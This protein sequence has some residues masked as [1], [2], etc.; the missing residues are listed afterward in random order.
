MDKKESRQ[1]VP[2]GL[3]VCLKLRPASGPLLSLN[4]HWACSILRQPFVK[5]LI[6]VS[7]S[8]GVAVSPWGIVAWKPPITAL[9]EQSCGRT[10]TMRTMARAFLTKDNSLPLAPRRNHPALRFLSPLMLFIPFKFSIEDRIY[11]ISLDSQ[12]LN[13]AVISLNR[14]NIALF[15]ILSSFFKVS[16]IIGCIYL[17]FLYV[18]GEIHGET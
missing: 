16:C 1:D 11:R 5:P 7:L 9:S 10:A 17:I 13:K 3:P 8:C 2:L 6:L 12:T 4:R 14:L 18:K 15:W